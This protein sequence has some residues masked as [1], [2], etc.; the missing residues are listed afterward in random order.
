MQKLHQMEREPAYFLKGIE[1]LV[2]RCEKY[3][4]IRGVCIEK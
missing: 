2:H 4:E 1:L 3:F